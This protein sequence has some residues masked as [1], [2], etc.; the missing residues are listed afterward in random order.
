MTD[1]PKIFADAACRLE[2][3]SWAV[4]VVALWLG[5][6]GV[7]AE[8]LVIP[9]SGNP[10]HLL[11]RLADAFN[12]SQTV[13]TVVIPASTGTAGALRDVLQATESMGRVGRPL[14]AEERGMGLTYVPLGRDAVVFVGGAGV[15][16]RSLSS[17][18]VVD[19]YAGKLRDWKDA[20]GG[21]GPIRAVGRE[22][23]DASRQAISRAI[24]AFESIVFGDLVKVVHLDPQLLEILDRYPTS[25]GFLNRSALRAART[26]LVILALDGVEPSAANLASGRY[27]VW[28]EFGLVHRN[29]ALSDAGAAFLRFIRSP[30]GNRLLEEAGVLPAAASRR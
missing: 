10:E 7:G 26:P 8:T 22:P 20:G 25:L 30:A 14:S 23:S 16:V 11:G 2:R 18:Q 5:I 6:G 17:G 27:P 15:A 13:H 21:R 24:R 3:R 19:I 1:F 9:G 28:L 12:A 29:N 4:A